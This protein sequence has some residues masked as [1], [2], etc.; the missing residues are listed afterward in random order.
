MQSVSAFVASVRASPP[1][2][3]EAGGE[4]W[5]YKDEDCA[6][7]ADFGFTF[8]LLSIVALTALTGPGVAFVAWLNQVASAH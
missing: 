3:D 4:L 8:A 2:S 7:P 1:V 5:S 6:S